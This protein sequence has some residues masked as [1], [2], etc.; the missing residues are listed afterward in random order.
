MELL[1]GESLASR[2]ARGDVP[3]SEAV[4]IGLGMLA[5][6]EALHGN[7]LVHRDLKPSNVFLTPNGIK[8]LDFGLTCAVPDSASETDVRMTA[9]GTVVGTPQYA[10]PEQL[11]GDAVDARTD[12]FAAGV[13]LYEILAGRP[14][15]RGHTAVEIF[16]AVIYEQPPVLTGGAAVAALDC[17]VARALAKSPADRYQT[18]AAMMEDLRASQVSSDSGVSRPVRAMTRLI[19]IAPPGAAT[20]PRHGFPGVQHRRRGDERALRSAVAGRAIEPCGLAPRVRLAGPEKDCRR[21]GSGRRARRHAAA[22]RRSG[23]RLDAAPRGA[24]SDGALVA[25]GTGSGRGFH[26]PGGRVD[27][28]DRRS[29]SVPLNSRERQ[30]LKQD[31]PRAPDVYA[32]YLRANELGRE[33]KHWRTALDLYD[34]CTEQDPQYAPAWAGVGRMRR[35]IGKYVEPAEGAHFR[36]AE[37]ALKRALALNPDFSAA[38]N[39]YAHLEVDLGRA[40]EA[41]VRLVRLARRRSADPELYAALV[42]ACR[43]CGLLAASAAAADHARRLDP[44][45]RTTAAHTY[46][47]LGEYQRA[48]DYEV[49][50]PLLPAMAL[51]MMGRVDEAR[52]RLRAVDAS[53]QHPLSVHIRGL[54]QL[55]AGDPAGLATMRQLRVPD[56]E[57]GFH[58]ARHFAHLGDPRGRARV[59]QTGGRGGIFLPA[60]HDPR[61]VARQP[62]RVTGVRRDPAPRRIA[63]PPG[64]RQLPDGGGRSCAGRDFSGVVGAVIVGGQVIPASEIS[65]PAFVGPPL[66]QPG[67]DADD[68]SAGQHPSRGPEGVCRAASTIS[69]RLRAAR[70]K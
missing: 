18:A 68:G 31:V 64:R 32:S 37:L 10:A 60:R 55:P 23:A 19:V 65:E 52:E 70:M 38:E 3:L 9:P 59:A 41:M 63:A 54:Q 5:G 57:G 40:E 48:I 30:S 66:F 29:L 17:V 36:Q 62:A 53:D 50:G 2:I 12:L 11:R 20:R 14:P 51:Y 28:E 21:S 67:S 43:Y 25:H 47:M 61:P 26:H 69:E 4:S 22:R 46:F 42:T 58:I 15:F 1:R 8:L 6:L 44:R 34:R 24:G 13:V 7:G 27:D 39:T 35:L 49:G 45:V 56:P 16:H 33:T